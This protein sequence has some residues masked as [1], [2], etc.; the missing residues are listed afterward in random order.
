M[1]SKK[2]LVPLDGS[3][4]AER[5]LD[6]VPRLRACTGEV[7]LLSV[8]DPVTARLPNLTPYSRTRTQ[9]EERRAHLVKQA[10]NLGKQCPEVNIKVEIGSPATVIITQ[11]RSYDMIVLTAHGWSDHTR[12]RYSDIVQQI[13]DHASCQVA[14]IPLDRFASIEIHDPRTA[15]AGV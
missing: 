12:T 1:T 7:T 2:L 8:I 14:V 13:L 5:A 11:S 10:R 6:Y 9:F 4:V 3:A 15:T